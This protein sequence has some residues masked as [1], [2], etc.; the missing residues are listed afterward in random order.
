MGVDIQVVTSSKTWLARHMDH[1][2]FL[3]CIT[4]NT[5]RYNQG[6][7]VEIGMGA[8][9]GILA[10]YATKYGVRLYSCDLIMGGMWRAFNRELFL[11]HIC[12]IGKSEDFIKQFHD[13]PAVV[14]IDGQHDYDVVKMETDFFLGRMKL[15]GVLL[16]HDTWPPNE[17]QLGADPKAHDVYKVRQDLERNP[18]LD[19]FTWPFSALNMG[20][21][22]VMNHVP[23]K[24]RGFWEKNGRVYQAE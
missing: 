19:V 18:D 7:I 16:M 21:T 20:L 14:F 13:E 4:N 8:S 1:W 9:S 15:N 10:K 22:M 24:R 3:D 12:F 5:L 6:C 23:N 11:D 17:E 2:G